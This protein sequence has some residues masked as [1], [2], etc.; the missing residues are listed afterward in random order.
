MHVLLPPL[1]MLLIIFG[2]HYVCIGLHELGHLIAIKCI[3]WT[4]L[5]FKLGL[6]PAITVARVGDLHVQLG[7]NPFSGWVRGTAETISFFRLKWFLMVISGP[8]M[9]ALAILAMLRVLIYESNSPA[10]PAWQTNALF[11]AIMLQLMTLVGTLWPSTTMMDGMPMTTDGKQAIQSITMSKAEIVGQFLLHAVTKATVLIERGEWQRVPAILENARLQ[12]GISSPE[13]G[14]IWICCLLQQ[15]KAAQAEAAM[16]DLLACADA[17]GET[18]AAVLDSLACLPLFDGH[19]QLI[20]KALT[21]IE[22]A[23]AAAPDA[24][25]LKGTKASLLIEAGELASGMKL[26]EEVMGRTESDND[27]AICSYYLAL[28]HARS[29]D[30]KKGHEF[31]DTAERKYPGCVVKNRVRILFWG[32]R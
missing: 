5:V 19:T 10:V 2:S 26:L 14:R 13:M 31:L 8:L 20:P 29:G 18:R 21:Y 11:I 16:N 27:R 6:G 25:T 4:P 30:W 9:T 3:G 32:S 24:I 15:G 17:S 22:E 23:I 7:R 28:A 1:L 12:T